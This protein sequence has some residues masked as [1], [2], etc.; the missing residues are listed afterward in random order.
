MANC[1]NRLLKAKFFRVLRNESGCQRNLHPMII[2]DTNM[3]HE[4]H[5]NALSAGL[6]PVSY[7]LYDNCRKPR[8]AWGWL[9][10]WRNCLILSLCLVVNAS[11]GTYYIDYTTGLD[12]NSGTSKSTPWKRCPGM[13]GFGGTYSH[14]AGDRFIFKGG[15]TWPR[16][17]FQFH[18]TN[19]G[20]SGNPDYYRQMLHGITAV[21]L[22]SRSSILKI[23]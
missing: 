15:V 9:G 12:S 18:I 14:S 1:L 10:R 5:T 17:V 4:I 3:E 6:R 21:P 2:G 13:V 7:A 23:L 16:S 8:W 11:G 20:A 22:Q 19:S